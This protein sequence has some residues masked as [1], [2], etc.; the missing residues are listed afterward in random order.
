MLKIRDDQMKIFEQASLQK[1][2]ERLLNHFQIYFPAHWHMLG[3]EHLLNVIRLGCERAQLYDLINERD[4]CLYISLMLYLGSFFDRDIQL[5]W[6]AR[7]LR[8]NVSE[9][10]TRI[11]LLYE[12]TVDYLEQVIG[13]NN[14]YSYAAMMN[15]SHFLPKFKELW[16]KR[17]QISKQQFLLELR[18]LYPE[19]YEA[20]GESNLQRLIRHGEI[21]A[22][23]YGISEPYGAML[24]IALMFYLG[25]D[26]DKDPQFP[27]ASTVLQQKVGITRVGLAD[28]LYAEVTKQV[29]Q[30]LQ[31][32]A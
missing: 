25:S 3:R 17:I 1:F 21:N 6:T 11:V 27:W 28:A 22:Q 13:L 30:S 4:I 32:Y 31:F 19:K 18:Q 9:P 8:N 15:A 2:E 26:F 20:V 24:Y 16:E 29:S 14:E 10:S 7:I 23:R 5:R 12:T